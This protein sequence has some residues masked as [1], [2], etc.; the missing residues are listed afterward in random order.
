MHVLIATTGVLSSEPVV[1]FTRQLLGQNGKVTVM[2][3]I[4]VPRQFLDDLQRTTGGTRGDTSDAAADKY[5]QE[6][7]HRLVESVAQALE[8]ARIPYE[9]I[10]VD[11]ADP[12]IAISQTAGDLDA[13]VVVLGATRPIFDRDAWESV[14]ARVMLECGKPVLVVPSPPDKVDEDKEDDPV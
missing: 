11:G 6:R 3:V 2:T 10:Y 7:G 1:E 13:D 5:L 14:S 4:E 8:G 9:V 12:A